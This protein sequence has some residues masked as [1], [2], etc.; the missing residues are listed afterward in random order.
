M[1]E[2]WQALLALEVCASLVAAQGRQGADAEGA[3]RRAARI[4]GAAQALRET[5]AAPLVPINRDHYQRG[6][7]ATRA[8]LD[9][10]TFAAAWAAAAR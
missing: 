7:A 9:D 6:V 10:A 4:F 1:G 3:G 8:L 2:Q 5:L